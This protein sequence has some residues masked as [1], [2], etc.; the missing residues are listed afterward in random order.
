MAMTH[1]LT[2]TVCD[3]ADANHSTLKALIALNIRT[4]RAPA[5]EII[6]ISDTVL[7]QCAWVGFILHVYTH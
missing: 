1:V 7:L 2:Y 5:E 3:A 6:I 4:G